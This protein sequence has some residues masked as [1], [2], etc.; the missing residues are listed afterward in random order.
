VRH[1]QQDPGH[2]SKILALCSS[3][4][5]RRRAQ[6]QSRG[7]REVLL[8]FIGLSGGKTSFQSET[9]QITSSL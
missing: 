3:E 8:R 1:D 6:G 2:P 5:A 4:V 9:E 7:T